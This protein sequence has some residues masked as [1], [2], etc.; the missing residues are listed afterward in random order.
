[1]STITN[2]IAQGWAP[3]T[4][5]TYAA[6]LLAF[7]T[8]CDDRNI[9]EDE[10]APASEDLI[11]I[12]LATLTGTCSDSTL[13]NYIAGLRAWHL[14]HRI[15]WNLGSNVGA[16][17]VRAAKRA[18]GVNFTRDP[19]LPCTVDLLERLH[20]NLDLS[21][22]FD[23]AVFACATTALYCMARLGEFTPNTI[24][25]PFDPA[26]HIS[27]DRVEHDVQ[28]AHGNRVTIFHL[29]WTKIAPAGEDV[30]WAEQHGVSDPKAALA[31]H[32]AANSPPPGHFLFSYIVTLANGKQ[33]RKVLSQHSFLSRIRKAARTE[34]RLEKITAHSF[35]IGGTIWC[36]LRGVPFDVVR[37]KGRW[38]GDSF[39]RYLRRHGEIMAPYVQADPTVWRGVIREISNT[40]EENDIPDEV[41]SCLD[42]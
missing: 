26:T 29:P 18:K 30:F 16:L 4:R 6:A 8:I 2:T 12:F 22:N 40:V 5:T 31:R 39:K 1:M 32:L 3:S 21:K 34:P 33:L 37:E 23:I 14:M 25:T 9:P 35:R 42:S 17:I 13:S 38:A 27:I 28:D 41:S 11:L 10:R 15:P 24:S 20:A 19:K 7:H 36:L